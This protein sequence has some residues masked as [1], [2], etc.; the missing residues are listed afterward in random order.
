MIAIIFL[1]LSVV[2]IVFVAI[3]LKY[4][5]IKMKRNKSKSLSNISSDNEDVSST[6]KNKNTMKGLF[7]IESIKDSLIKL[8]GNRYRVVL[9][10]STP[11][12]E[13]LT[14]QEE[15]SF[16]TA[17]MEFALSISSPI[18]FH[19]TTSKVETK[20]PSQD[21]EKLLS[22]DDETISQ[23][24]KDS[25]SKTLRELKKIEVQRGTFV[26]KSYCVVGVDGIPDEKRAVNQL[27]NNVD[28]IASGLSRARMKISLLGT[29]QGAQLL[30]NSFNKD[31]NF[32]I[33]QMVNE[34]ALEL[35]TE[36]LGVIVHEEKAKQQSA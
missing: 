35:Y 29:Y 18:M 24:L 33:E 26:R 16:E 23:E 3:Y 12:I 11:D 21:I 19:I 34:G 28:T 10:I 31:S 4:D 2:F 20:E 6:A 15:E 13:L 1:V 8:T 32:Q 36:G 9:A 30:A 14:D 7:E 27:K 22:S 17:L 25:A 5:T